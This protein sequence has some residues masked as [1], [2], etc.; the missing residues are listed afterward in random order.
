[1]LAV[2]CTAA[3]AQPKSDWERE[4]EQRDWREGEV[5]LPAYPKRED[6]IEFPVSAASSFRFHVDRASLS[7]GADGVVRYTLVARSAAGVENVSYEGIRCSGRI[8]KVYAFGRDNGAW[9]RPAETDWRPAESVWTRALRRD[10]FCPLGIAIGDVAE[11]LDALRRGQ[12]PA[13]TNA[14]LR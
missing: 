10:F 2:V 12:H 13:L 4:Q 11:G 1:M 7:V 6:L 8:Y 3:A 14:P 9:S 5:K